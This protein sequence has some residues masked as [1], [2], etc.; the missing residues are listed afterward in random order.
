MM[1][2]VFAVF[3]G[4][5]LGSVLR[6]LISFRLNKPDSPIAVGTLTANCIGAF[7]MGLGLAYFS[8]STHLDPIWKLMLTTGFCGGLTTFSTFSA[9]VV[10]LL[11]AGKIGWALANILANVA[12]SLLMT[13]LAFTV[14]NKL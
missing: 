4:G 12:G 5:G 2:I 3:V 8:K 7:I 10:Y 11:Q 6:W 1:N 13:T 14:I 9:E